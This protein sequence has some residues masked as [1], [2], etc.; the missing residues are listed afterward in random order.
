M[1]RGGGGIRT[2]NPSKRAAADQR[3]RL[4]GHRDRHIRKG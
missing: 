1:R 4:R 3:L 2:R